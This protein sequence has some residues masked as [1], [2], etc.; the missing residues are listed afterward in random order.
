MDIWAC[1][2][3]L[4]G[5]A[6]QTPRVHSPARDDMELLVEI[7]ELVGWKPLKQAAAA[8]GEDH[9]RLNLRTWT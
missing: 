5:L 1:G 4:L 9:C 6:T 8:L 3:I 2:I 7:G